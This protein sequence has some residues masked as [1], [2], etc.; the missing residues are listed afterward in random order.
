M[1]DVDLQCGWLDAY[2][3]G[4]LKGFR[5]DLTVTMGASKLLSQVLWQDCSKERWANMKG[6]EHSP[7]GRGLNPH[8]ELRGAR[9]KHCPRDLGNG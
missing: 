4:D 2:V 6:T 5:S 7:V 3:T 9:T 1:K 8:P